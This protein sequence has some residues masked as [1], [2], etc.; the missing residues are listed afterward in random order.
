MTDC[1]AMDFQCLLCGADGRPHIV[2]NEVKGDASGQLK[3]VRC[4]TCSHV[5]LSPP[6]YDF[7]LYQEDGQVNYVIGHYG[8]P[9]ETLFDHSAIEA[10]RRVQRFGQHGASLARSDGEQLRLLD[11]GGGYG[12]FGSAMKRW[13]P[14]VG[15]LVLEPSASRAE[16]GRRHFADRNDPDFPTPSFEVGLLDQDYVRQHV[17]AFDV[18]TLW[19]VLEHVEDPLQLMER[20]G[21][22]LR[23][24]GG[25][26]WIEVPNVEDELA[27]L[28]PAY[29]QR[30]YMRE[31]I[32][33]FSAAVLERMARQVFPGASVE[34]S[35]YQRYGIFNYFHWIHFNAPQG[36]SPDLWDRDRWWLE[37]AWRT[38]REAARTSDALLLIVRLGDQAEKRA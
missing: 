24:E 7:D 6:R 21:A 23:A 15:T 37:T 31:H 20:A 10:K 1:L 35:G 33:Y 13:H 17:G 27:T 3:A 30:S 34:V 19:H 38:A 32:S 26:L 9:I 28:S 22:L 16:T 25:S 2:Q 4:L 29:R 36:A 8:T 12:F 18:V 5:Q 11:V 14:D